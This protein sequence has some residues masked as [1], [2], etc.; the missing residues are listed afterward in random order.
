MVQ[1]T[2]AG[3]SS[4]LPIPDRNGMRINTQTLLVALVCSLGA[5]AA[6]SWIANRYTRLEALRQ[7]GEQDAATAF[8]IERFHTMASQW[9]VTIDLF[10][11]YEQTYLANG[12][13][14]QA[15][16]LIE[17]S[18]RLKENPLNSD[19]YAQLEKL[20][21]LT[22]QISKIVT[23]A[24]VLN[25][26]TREQDWNEHI[27]NFDTKSIEFA[28]T[29]ETAVT[30][31][32]KHSTLRADSIAQARRDLYHS[33]YFSAATYFLAVILAWRW[34]TQN[35]VKPI[36]ALAR[37]ALAGSDGKQKF[38]TI[39]TGG[40]YEVRRLRESIQAYAANLEAE[41]TRAKAEAQ[42]AMQAKQRIDTFLHTAPNAILSVKSNGRILSAN[43]AS[44]RI[45]GYA[46]SESTKLCLSNLLPELNEPAMQLT[47]AA[48]NGCTIGADWE[49]R[50][51]NGDLFPTEIFVSSM[52]VEGESVYVVIIHETTQRKRIE[53]QLAQAEK[54]KSIGQLSAGIAH[55]IN[56]P[57]QYIGDNVEFL[58]DSILTLFQL[59]EEYAQF[60]ETN[61]D[62]SEIDRFIKTAGELEEQLDIA[63][64]K[65]EAPTAAAQ[66][67]EGVAQVRRIVSS[68]KTFSHP[69]QDFPLPADLN[70]I[71]EGA[72]TIAA[73]EW[74]YIAELETNL[75]EGLPTISC[76]AGELGQ[77]ITNLT[78]NAAH[79]IEETANTNEKGIIRISTLETDSGIEIRVA[80]TGAGIPDSIKDQIFDPFFTTKTVGKGTGQ[81]L[82]IAYSVIKKHQGSIGV[83]S[84]EGVGTTF[85]LTLP[86]HPAPESDPKLS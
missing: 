8:D 69:G 4:P 45:F 81:G 66:T 74:K 42:R 84:E 31:A 63:F 19:R 1:A 53:S 30:G 62:I 40:P 38:K 25:G 2:S 23:E 78:I 35:T 36:E 49:G 33:L 71:I 64:L 7:I 79:A 29:T 59:V 10:F 67:M 43:R 3:E 83:E 24:S 26:E 13:Q 73:N 11:G 20:S 37:A 39:D 72:I 17:V 21:N 9:F 32:K 55:E 12:I 41:K 5:I 48:A 77:V 75:A 54:L 76:Y 46:S 68:M 61:S 18:N 52:T 16:D 65:T 82:S 80:D 28:K 44:H 15:K 50:K 34:A 14:N 60:L 85:I 70:S 47:E 51:K 86:L 56:S 58:R 6:F 22:R 57:V 27:L